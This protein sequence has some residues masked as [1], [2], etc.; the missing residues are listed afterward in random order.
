MIEVGELELNENPDN[1]FTH[2][3]QVAFAPAN[4]VDGILYSP[5]INVAR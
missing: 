1:Y 3:E 4:V 2:V 5:D